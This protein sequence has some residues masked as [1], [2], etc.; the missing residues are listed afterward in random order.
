MDAAMLDLARQ[1]M[2]GEEGISKLHVQFSTEAVQDM[3]AS[4]KAGKP[5]F[6]DQEFITIWIPGDKDNTPKQPVDD[7]YRALFHTQYQNFKAN[8]GNVDVGTPLSNLPFMSPAQVAELGYY[9]V[10]TV[11]QL[12][13]MADV[14][15]Q[16][17]MGF[18]ALKQKAQKYLDAINGA[19]PA[20]KLQEELGKRDDEIEALKRLVADQTERIEKMANRKG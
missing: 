5:V 14:N 4:A 17:V 12:V 8:K 2:G 13:G 7:R 1:Q 11:E 3:E 16:K 20:Q 18:Q 10:K 9:G 6:K 19:A 15:G